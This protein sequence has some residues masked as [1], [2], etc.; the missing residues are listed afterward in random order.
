M[1]GN[2]RDKYSP[3]ATDANRIESCA[4]VCRSPLSTH[5]GRA[6]RRYCVNTIVIGLAHGR[7]MGPTIFSSK[8]IELNF[9]IPLMIT[10]PP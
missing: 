9:T 4:A 1:H 3:R 8:W 7:S 5:C 6:R 10:R 2:D